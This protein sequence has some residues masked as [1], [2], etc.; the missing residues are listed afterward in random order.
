MRLRTAVTA[1]V[2]A[3]IAVLGGSGIAAADGFGNDGID[4]IDHTATVVNFGDMDL[5]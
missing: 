3:A 1:T 4:V 2:L 5:D